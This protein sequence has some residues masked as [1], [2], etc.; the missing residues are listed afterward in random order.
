MALAQRP[1]RIIACVGDERYP[2]CGKTEERSGY[3]A[4]PKFCLDCQEKRNDR[5][6]VESGHRREPRYRKPRMEARP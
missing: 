4:K 3:G 2:G 5:F 1:T 6:D